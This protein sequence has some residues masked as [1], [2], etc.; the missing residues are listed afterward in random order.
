MVRPTVLLVA[1]LIVISA[2]CSKSSGS[3]PAPPAAH[4][5]AVEKL[6]G[7]G[8]TKKQATCVVDRL[9]TDTV[10]EAVDLNA[11]AASGPYRKASESCIRRGS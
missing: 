1:A 11:L 9:G 4:R 5:Q 10:V 8:L 3:D 6:H 2:G 7:Y